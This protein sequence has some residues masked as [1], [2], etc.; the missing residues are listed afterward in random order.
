[1]NRNASRA[2]RAGYLGIILGIDFNRAAITRQC[3]VI[4][5]R[6]DS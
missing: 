5:L 1:M 4:N 2:E 3:R 6:F